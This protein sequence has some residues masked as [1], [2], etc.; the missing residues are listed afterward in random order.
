MKKHHFI[1]ARQALW[2]RLETLLV[3]MEAQKTSALRQHELE[4]FVHLHRIACSDLARSRGEDLGEDVEGYLNMLVARGYKQFHPP[5]PP[6]LHTFTDFFRRDFPRAVRTQSAFV[7]TAALLFVVPIFFSAYVV[8]QN[9][10]DAYAITPPETL[11]ALT[12]AYAEGHG[13]GRSEA[14]DTAM[15]GYYINNNIGIAFRCFATGIF[16]GLGSI[17]FLITN[18]ILGGAMGAYICVSGHAENFFAFVVGHS[19]FELTAI[20]LAGATGLKL[21]MLL[22]NPG[23]FTRLD[24]LRHSG[25]EMIRVILGSTAMLF[26][27]ALIEGFWS[28]SGAPSLVKFA[29]GSFLWIAVVVYLVFA[30]RQPSRHKD[31][32]AIREIRP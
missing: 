1:T 9:P 7:L 28:P 26:L 6:K 16:F 4:E 27:A 17:F 14:L 12:Q 15:T 20:I 11:E 19:S 24:A 2:K 23:R 10:A 32:I 31:T 8:A 13:G 25:T 29:V 30:G 22:V 3:K 21:G 18:G 5:T